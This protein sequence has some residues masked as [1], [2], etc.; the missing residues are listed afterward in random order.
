MIYYIIYLFGYLVTLFLNIRLRLEDRGTVTLND[1]IYMMFLLFCLW[2]LALI[3]YIGMSSEN[4]ILWR[5]K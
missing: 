2:P 1:F 3:L 5:K 4:I